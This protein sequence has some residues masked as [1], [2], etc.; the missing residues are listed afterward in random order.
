MLPPS[1]I[2][3]PRPSAG[4]PPSRTRK[5][6]GSSKPRLTVAMSPRRNTRPFTCTG[7]AAIASAP[8]NAPVTRR[9]MRSAEVS[10]EP[11]AITA[12]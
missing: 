3:T 8:E 6:G 2:D 12:F 5:L 4:R 7:T 9:W 1:C 11:P 10:T